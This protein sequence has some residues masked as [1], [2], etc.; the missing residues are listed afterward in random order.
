MTIKPEEYNYSPTKNF[1]CERFVQFLKRINIETIPTDG[2]PMR[3]VLGAPTNSAVPDFWNKIRKLDD[4]QIGR[5]FV[6]S[7]IIGHLEIQKIFKDKNATEGVLEKNNYQD[8]EKLYTNLARDLYDSKLTTEFTDVSV[9]YNFKPLLKDVNPLYCRKVIEAHL[10][11]ADDQLEIANKSVFLEACKELN[12]N[13]IFGIN[14]TEFIEWLDRS[15]VSRSSSSPQIS[16]P[17]LLLSGISGTGKSRFVRLQAAQGDASIKEPSNYCLVPVRPDWHEPSD[18]LGYVSRIRDHDRYIPTEFLKFMVK[19]WDNATDENGQIKTA[20]V[21]TYWLCLDE[22]NL[23]PVEQYFADYLSVLENREWSGAEYTCAPLLKAEVILSLKDKEETAEGVESSG[24]K[25]FRRDVFALEGIS[26]VKVSAL[27]NKFMKKGKGI[28]LPPNLIVAGTV[29][30]DETTHGFSR[31]VI[32]RALTLDF[33]EFFPNDFNSFMKKTQIP[34][35]TL[36]FSTLSHADSA[37]GLEALQRTGDPDGEKTV[38]FMGKLNKILEGTSFELAYRALNECL[39]AVACQGRIVQANGSP[40]NEELE[41]RLLAVWDDF[42]MQKVLP[43]IEGDAAKLKF[44]GASKVEGLN[45]VVYGKESILHEL[46]WLL[47]S[48][49]L[50]PIWGSESDAIEA[51]KDYDPKKAIGT[52][53]DLLR[54]TKILIICRSRK[55]LRWMMK[56]LKA[57]HFTDFWV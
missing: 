29:N 7:R 48:D 38:E 6:L 11:R 43:R 18:L 16:K 13:R 41:L 15:E 30:M 4:N 36:G 3:K 40:T 12:L 35:I 10:L 44:A 28:P 26:E 5:L 45:D 56:R 33:Q 39:L 24:I 19:A 2:Y 47:G 50:K 37:E 17:F 9:S 20:D 25:S 14:F 1:R 52:R 42:L 31:K 27:W 54:D 23:A 49:C 53:P 22:M 57:N 34:P 21:G 46:Y 51:V 32:D 8:K 55:K